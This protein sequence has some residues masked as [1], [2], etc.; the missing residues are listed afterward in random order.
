[1]INSDNPFGIDAFAAPAPDFVKVKPH[2]L[3]KTKKG[4]RA[5]RPLL[6]S[7]VIKNILLTW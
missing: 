2:K 3:P 6:P 7:V 5:R 1:M 4:T